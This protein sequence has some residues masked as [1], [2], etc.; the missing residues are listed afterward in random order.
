MSVLGQSLPEGSGLDPETLDL[1]M[2]RLKVDLQKPG[3]F[4]V[5]A[6]RGLQGETN[7]L[8]FRLFGR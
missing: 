2:K 7:R 1:E 6:C 4:A 8:P 5:I 3:R